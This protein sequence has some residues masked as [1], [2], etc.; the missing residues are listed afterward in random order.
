M[1][2]GIDPTGH[3]FTHQLGLDKV[4]V[5][6]GGNPPPV[7][8]PPP[9]YEKKINGLKDYHGIHGINGKDFLFFRVFRG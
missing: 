9:P 4:L 1:T 8:N 5:Q 2:V 6:R 3:Y 7:T